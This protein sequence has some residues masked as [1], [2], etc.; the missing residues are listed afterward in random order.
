MA[1]AGIQVPVRLDAAQA[2]RD[3]KNLSQS[4]L[5]ALTPV[6]DVGQ[7][8]ASAFRAVGSALSGMLSLAKEAVK[9]SSA[10]EA[11]EKRLAT[12]LQ[13]RGQYTKEGHERL[14]EYAD[15][16]E[17]ATNVGSETTL[18][19][20]SQLSALG[21]HQREMVAATE[22]TLGLAEVMGSTDAAAVQVA[23]VLRGETS[24]SLK[25]LGLDTG[26][27]NATFGKLRD[28]FDLTKERAETFE[29]KIASLGNAWE[30]LL[31]EFGQAVINNPEVKA[32]L[33][34]MVSALSSITEY[35]RESGP[36]IQEF[37]S[38]FV[39]G[40][41]SVVTFA[42]EHKDDFDILRNVFSPPVAIAN[43]FSA[44][45]KWFG[46][47]SEKPFQ[48]MTYS[49]PIGPAPAPGPT[50]IDFGEDF[51]VGDIITAKKPKAT[52]QREERPGYQGIDM[53]PKRGMSEGA[54]RHQQNQL[55]LEQGFQ[56]QMFSIR[57]NTR[58]LEAEADRAAKEEAF[59]RSV[60][61]YEERK[62][63]TEE[64]EK[65]IN[66]TGLKF[67][68]VGVNALT[69]TLME[70][71]A[72]HE[73]SLNKIAGASI[74]TIGQMIQ[75]AGF[76][77]IAAGVMGTAIP[78]F[79]LE[80][81]GPAAIAAGVSALAVG[82]GIMA[83]GAAMGGSGGRRGGGGTRASGARGGGGGSGSGRLGGDVGFNSFA[84]DEQKSATYIIN[85]NRPVGD[86]R[87]VARE[88]KD[89]L[90]VSL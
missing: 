20:Q 13:L 22:A 51:P 85:F 88:L 57:E 67:L 68:S 73:V 12:A 90:Q 81:G 65:Q 40:L 37:I 46:G 42:R 33:S 15:A 19:L 43:T 28:L 49:S 47:Q 14:V 38:A 21:V 58:K 64:S 62:R 18:G 60:D 4:F 71:A 5:G 17:R 56:E 80:L 6:V 79:A 44:A 59:Q 53:L 30:D 23:K 36:K 72:G 50:T 24:R 84:L 31:K 69:T 39:S 7:L 34:D 74:I 10:Q 26:D 25:Q 35:I 48:P 70:A 9:L 66:E 82:A 63:L 77:A 8:A 76:A 2:E 52:R 27:A 87:R 1:T 78:F 32:L 83:V 11:A 45:R 3:A 41:R 55:E 89:A 86:P 75:Q 29:G 16:L 61:A 54:Q